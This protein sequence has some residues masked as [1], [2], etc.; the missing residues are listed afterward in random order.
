MGWWLPGPGGGENEQILVKGHK[1]SVIQGEEVLEAYHT[2]S[3][4]YS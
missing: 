3:D 2:A 1:V 4:A